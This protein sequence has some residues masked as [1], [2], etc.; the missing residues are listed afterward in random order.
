MEMPLEIS[1]ASGK[2]NMDNSSWRFFPLPLLCKGFVWL[3]SLLLSSLVRF[4]AVHTVAAIKHQCGKT[5]SSLEW[6]FLFCSWNYSDLPTTDF[7]NAKDVACR[8]ERSI[9]ASNQLN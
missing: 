7:R 6:W 1:D 2:C 5:C 9:D 4:V 3:V 8:R